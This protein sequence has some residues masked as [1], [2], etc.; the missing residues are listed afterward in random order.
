ML[1]EALRVAALVVTLCWVLLYSV[2]RTDGPSLTCHS[3]NGEE[4]DYRILVVGE[5]WACNG[6]LYPE[7]PRAVSERLHGRKSSSCSLCFPGRNSRHLYSELRDKIP[8]DKLYGEIGGAPDKVVF[9]TGVNDEIQHIGESA[10]VEYTKKIIEY[11]SDVPDEELISIPR[12]DEVGFKPPNLFTWMKRSILRCVYDGCQ[13]S[14]NDK[15]RAALRRDHPDLPLIEFDNFI[16]SYMGH[17]NCYLPDG[18]HLTE[19]CLHSYGAFIGRTT[20]LNRVERPQQRV[21]LLR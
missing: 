2:K 19:A 10:Y 17:E 9:L 1:K 8:R 3:E 7:L 18:V 15:Y 5:S 4:P 12:V 20:S 21:D 6:G 14:V 11:F 16:G 13:V